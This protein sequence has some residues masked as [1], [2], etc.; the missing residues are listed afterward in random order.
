MKEIYKRY[1]SLISFSLIILQL[2]LL[3]PSTST[4]KTILSITTIPYLTPIVKAI[5]GDKIEVKCLIPPGA[6]PHHYE[7]TIEDIQILSQAQLIIMTGPSHLPVEVRIEELIKNGAIKAIMINYVN[8]TENG[9]NLLELPNGKTNPHGYFLSYSGI[10]SIAISVFKALKI[11]N[12]ENLD[13]YTSR[14]NCYL[15]RISKLHNSALSIMKE[16]KIKIAVFTPVLQYVMNDLE[17]TI[18]DFLVYEYGVE[19]SV[20]DIEHIIKL[21]K[22]KAV[23]FIV[24]TDIDAKR[25]ESIIETLKDEGLPL[26]VIPL[27]KAGITSN[28]ELTEILTAS[29]I[30]SKEQNSTSMLS[31]L[32]LSELFLFA[33]LIANVILTLTILMLLMKIRRIS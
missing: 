32:S 28:P 20:E 4:Q 7:L 16:K 3:F 27:L 12:P 14:F 9:L 13:Y 2:C 31:E 17:I 21:A 33:S 22:S 30:V 29:V 11:L 19:P 8:Y 1:A 18:L 5:G 25:Y 15:D 24:A 23:D 10:K 6:D 26:V